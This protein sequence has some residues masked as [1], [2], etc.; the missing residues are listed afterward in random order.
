MS[1]FD[2]VFMAVKSIF[3]NRLRS[4]LTMLGV[5]IGI[6]S[7]I[8]L[9]AIGEA[10]KVYVVAQVE[11]WGIGPNVIQINPGKDQTD[12]SAMLNSK[13]RVS[14]AVQIKEKSTAIDEVLPIIM[15]SAKARYGKKE[16]SVSQVW[17]GTDNYQKI[18]NHK[19]T[20]GKFFSK[21]DLDGRRS[22][23]M[24][25]TTVAK[26]LFGNFDPI[27]ERVKLTGRK[28]VVLGVFEE[29]GKMLNFDMDDIVVIPI[30]SAM[31]LFDTKGVV[32]ID[33]AA[34]SR[35]LVPKAVKEIHAVLGRRLSK[36][37]YQVTTQEGMMNML[38]NIV[39]LL[40]SVIGG[41]AAISLIVGSIGIM[42]IMLVSVT[43]RTK[44]IGIRKA[45]GARK[46]DVFSQ[47]L[48]ESV[49]ISFFGGL[50]GIVL[51]LAGTFLIMY[52][53][54]LEMVV[55]VWALTLAVTVS[56]FIGVIS[57]VYPAM[58]AVNLDPIEAL[59][60]E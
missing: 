21:G 42:N 48:I 43:E 44:E 35:E 23:C 22:V 1:F 38:N 2:S 32:E 33:V 26:K 20:S 11:S 45:V 18:F 39:G 58:R 4:A 57:G 13:L 55:V 31:S 52:V 59:R 17:G 37:D 25:G 41:I 60:Y 49:V 14:D 16:H 40:T 19:L 24:L 47:F 12:M 50:L 8:I 53:I 29:K 46:I 34:K 36:D 6:A 30:T 54:K 15:G 9:V 7:V 5:I 28:F 10:A 3:A 27:G 51:G 56:A